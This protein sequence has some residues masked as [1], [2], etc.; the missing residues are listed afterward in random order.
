[1]WDVMST[2]MVGLHVW[3]GHPVARDCW[4]SFE[5]LMERREEVR[6]RWPYGEQ[7]AKHVDI[8]HFFGPKPDKYSLR[9]LRSWRS[10]TRRR[11]Q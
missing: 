6:L 5:R 2:K 3:E 10:G 11:W 9:V 1:M 4:H 8:S 7:N